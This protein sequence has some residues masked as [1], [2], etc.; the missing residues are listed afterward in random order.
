MRDIAVTLVVGYLL[1]RILKYPWIGVLTYAWVSIFQPHK[2]AF[3]FALSQPYALLIALT[4]IASMIMHQKEVKFPVNGFTILLFMLPLWMSITTMFALMPDAAADQWVNVMKVF[5][6]A[7]VAAAL[8]RTRKHIHSLVWVLVGS[9]GFYGVKGGL[10]TLT[11]GGGE[12]VFGPPGSSFIS[13]NNAIAVALTMVIPLMYYLSTTLPRTWMKL[14]T[15]GAMGLSGIAVLG[16]QSRGAFLA[17][18]VTTL[19]LWLKSDK[20]ILTGLLLVILIPVAIGFMPETWEKRMKTTETYDEDMSA[21]GRLNSW[22]AAINIANDRPLVGGGFELY[23]YK[24]WAKYAPN[25]LFLNTAHSIYF[26]MLG[27]HGWLGLALFLTLGFMTW[28]TAGRIVRASRNRPDCAWAVTLAKSIQVSLIGY[29]SGGAFV[30]ISY[31]DLPY[32]EVLIV[33]VA[34]QLVAPKPTA[35]RTPTPV[36]ARGAEPKPSRAE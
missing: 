12:K 5:I 30:N 13:D 11:T 25:P 15:Y 29:A 23:S 4:T 14:A 21:Q 27:E 32:Y 28:V 19:F 6:F 36:P 31:W 17:I 22:Q 9:V 33:M 8:L 26:Q 16:S 10:F 7:L 24:V 2:H 18:G 34:Y 3:G 1:T 20:K 35:W